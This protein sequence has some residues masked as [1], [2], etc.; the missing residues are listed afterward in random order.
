MKLASQA[1]TV[2]PE[3]NTIDEANLA[4]DRLLEIIRRAGPHRGNEWQL[5]SRIVNARATL[6]R[7]VETKAHDALE[8][9]ERLLT[10]CADVERRLLT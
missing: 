10:V 3:P 9:A 7:A 5:Y 8:M 1:A 4:A 6:G 2:A